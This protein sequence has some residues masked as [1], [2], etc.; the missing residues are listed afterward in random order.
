M[1][2]LS[3]K[4]TEKIVQ[5]KI[6]PKTRWFFL[7]K[8]YFI[9]TMFTL[10]VVLG[11]FAFVVI[12]FGVTSNDW[13]IY[14]YLHESFGQ[15]LLLTLPYYWVG[16]MILFLGVAAYYYRHTSTGY[17]H[18]VYLIVLGSIGGSFL[19]GMIL[20]T[21]GLGDKL[22]NIFANKLPYYNNFIDQRIEMW[23]QPEKGLLSGK[24]LEV[25]DSENIKLRDLTRKEW[26]VD[27]K[28]VDD[29]QKKLIR[30]SEIIKVIGEKEGKDE[31]KAVEIRPWQGR[32]EKCRRHHGREKMKFYHG[33]DE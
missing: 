11:G 1:K 22:E 31:F 24:I 12:I 25:V 10:A 5:E 32:H 26:L 4:I 3:E 20:Y 6:R 29:E 18:K 17:R 2:N 16:L 21:F 15:Y 28:N 13:D 9:W 23:T 19:L 14:K 8:N 7:L 33:D 30:K 27:I